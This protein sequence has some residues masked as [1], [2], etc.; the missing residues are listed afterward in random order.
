MRF[1]RLAAQEHRATGRGRRA[2]EKSSSRWFLLHSG[3]PIMRHRRDRV[4]S[5]KSQLDGVIA[6]L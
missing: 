6:A 5:V 3:G 4:A 1:T 2:L